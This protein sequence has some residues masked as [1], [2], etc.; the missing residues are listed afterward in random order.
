MSLDA[1]IALTAGGVSLWLEVAEGRLPQVVHWGAALG[2][3]SA[4]DIR[5]ASLAAAAPPTINGIDASVRWSILP[6][7]V[8][9]V[10][11]R[12]GLIGHRDRTAWSPSWVV[13]VVRVD[14]AAVDHHR[15]GGPGLVTV[16]AVDEAAGLGLTLEIELTES[17]LVRL[18]AT[19]RNLMDVAYTVDSLAPCLPVPDRAV[20]LLD[21][22]G[23][24]GAERTPQRLPFAIGTHLRENRRGR[25]GADSAY[26]LH[27]GTAG[28]GFRSGEVWALHVGW[29]GNHAHAAERTALGR[30]LLFGS[31]LLLPG[32]IVL[33]RDETY[34]TPWVYGSYG[35]GLDGVAARFHRFLRQRDTH[36]APARPVTLNCW[37]AVY[38]DHRLDRLVDLVDRAA[39]LGVERFVLDDGWFGS[40]RDDTR[41]LGDWTVS[42]EVWPDGLGPLIDAVTSR[43]L[44][45]GLWVEPEMV[46]LDSDLA[47]AH[48]DWIMQV[49][50]HLPPESRHQH[51]LNLTIPECYDHIRSA[52][53]AL[54]DTYDIAY[55]KWDHNRDLTEP[56]TVPLGGRAAVHAQT[57]QTYR[58]MAEL[59]A[60][61]P[62]LEIESCSS[63][64]S[65]ADLGI[66]A[67]CDRIWGSDCTEPEERF[68][69]NRW[70]YQLLPP[71][72]I[73]SHVAAAPSHQTGR[74]HHVAFRAASALF[75][76]FGV[77]WDLASVPAEDLAQLEA[78]IRL[79]K[80]IRGLIGSGELVRSDTSDPEVYL[81]GFVAPD[82]ERA[83]Y[84]FAATTTP[85]LTNVWG[86]LRFEGLDPARSYEVRPLIPGVPV[87]EFPG[88]R[89]APW[90]GSAQGSAFQGGTFAGDV[91]ERVGLQAPFL[92]PDYPLLFLVRA[93]AERA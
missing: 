70:T 2:H 42:D 65:R 49:P 44:Q 40:R 15:A 62:G 61:R 30:R 18:R 3:D 1:T 74:M 75:A 67:I 52:L 77:E 59:K 20:E 53:T 92:I 48:P 64:G 7:A 87:G 54:L 33:H 57:E 22:A 85:T 35:V 24:W 41:G 58:L 23:H 83:V 9:G 6:G 29:S 31:E 11:G 80:E 93:T 72:V 78:W 26:V 71:E 34:T 32:E 28:F 4:A 25:T 5:S 84:C 14:G 47:R 55:L 88:L 76:H 60:H 79:Y 13:S 10:L 36:P 27:A 91:L 82:R 89:P 43:G 12:P 45:F 63:G 39:V 37:E 8:A 90:F 17:G 66:M 38:F 68:R 73:G 19:L 50:G 69:I 86:P 46:N 21:L 51:V 56:G 81:T 16:D